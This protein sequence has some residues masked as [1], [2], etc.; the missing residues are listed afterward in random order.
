MEE[1]VYLRFDLRVEQHA[2][3]YRARVFD[4]PVGE[5]ATRFIP[6][7][8]DMGRE[9]W[10][11]KTA[12]ELGAP[13]FDTVFDGEVRSCLRRSLDE[14]DR[15]GKGLR[16]R[17]HLVDVPELAELPWEYLYDPTLDRF[18]CL[19]KETPIVRY[20]DLPQ[21]I[22]P[23]AVQPPLCVL[24]ILSSPRDQ[25]PLDL[26]HEWTKLCQATSPLEQ[27]G[28]L[29]LERLP[30]GEATLPALQRRLRQRPYHVF[31]YVGH[32]GFD[33]EAQDGVLILEDKERQSHAVSGQALGVLLHN[34]RTLRLAI[35][36]ACE[37]ARA[38]PTDP[39][40]GTAQ[41]LVR[42]RI[43]AV[44]AM[45][46]EISDE[47][48]RTLATEF[49]AALADGYPVDAALAEA[50]MA[51]YLQ[52]NERE[53]GTPV[54]YMRAPDGRV[55][56]IAP[57]EELEPVQVPPAPVE[58]PAPQAQPPPP[59]PVYTQRA[60]PARGGD[61]LGHAQID[62]AGTLGCLVV[63][64]DDPRRVYI[65]CDLSGL[66]PPGVSPRAGDLVVQ[67]GRVD[68]GHP[69]TDVIARLSRWSEWATIS[70]VLRLEDVS[71]EIHERGGLRGVR[72][73]LPGM[74]VF[75]AG[76]T[77]GPVQGA[78]QRVGVPWGPSRDLIMTTPMLQ[79]GD[80]GA[81][82]IDA[83]NHAL[84]LGL[85]GSSEYSLF[86]P[87]QKVL[88][89]LNVDLVTEDLWPSIVTP[90]PDHGGV[91]GAAD[92]GE[93][94]RE[95]TDIR[96]HLERGRLV[97]F[98]G[99]DL[100]EWVTGLPS[101]QALADALA[102]REG[103]APE[104]RLADVAQEVMG[105]RSRWEFTDFLRESLDTTGKSPQPFHQYVVSLVRDAQL[106]TLLT[107][108]YDDLLELAFQRAGIGLNVVVRDQDL[109]FIRRD[110]PTL[111][112]LYGHW[113][114]ADT[115][116]VTEQDQNA[117]LRGRDKRDLVDEVRFAFRRNSI[118][119]LGHDLSDPAVSALFDELV[120]SGSQIPSFAVWSG[121]S[122]GE[123]DFLESKRNLTVL[124]TDPV[125]VVEAL[126][127]GSV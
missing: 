45:Q 58:Q 4:S 38:S 72:H 120:E 127:R 124:E 77:A 84:G 29:V 88:D 117:L 116:V 78:V 26:D 21:R 67:P 47:A 27:R 35:L 14:A 70:E 87:L 103:I 83:E 65:L 55:F 56:D 22:Q 19:S 94:E 28:L 118:L 93:Y 42:N 91:V 48:A 85:G 1:M 41:S 12:R 10:L 71:P 114:Q 113:R 75:A 30:E 111:L 36:N 24:A 74:Q 90:R 89:E 6:P 105:H 96:Q 53:W 9:E 51:V 40:A 86:V 3:E 61:S 68:G 54:L 5:A 16:I 20:L 106:E 66:Y 108:A 64:R 102:A 82:L 99:A 13:L 44:V 43:P 95:L 121:L 104:R 80:C 31:H 126:V 110:R 62:I 125:A 15:Q 97:L 50:R 69:D 73:A 39:F 81:I 7:F 109:A 17:L 18:F 46:F 59:Q 32:G 52:G 23:L 60:R 115:L 98:V 2:G 33:E 101:K 92:L 107:T 100:P 123:K 34:E 11:E 79:P 119:F 49:Y 63:D 122:Q 57:G 37:G 112:R 8:Q 76:R 25:P